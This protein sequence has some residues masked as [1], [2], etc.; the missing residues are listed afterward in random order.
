MILRRTVPRKAGVILKK[1]APLNPIFLPDKS[2]RRIQSLET[3]TSENVFCDINHSS[4]LWACLQ[5][6]KF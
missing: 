2:W 6:K 1:P 4:N 5:V 3:G